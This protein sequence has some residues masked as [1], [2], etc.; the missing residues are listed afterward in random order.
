MFHPKFKRELLKRKTIFELF[1]NAKK[2][3]QINIGIVID[4]IAIFIFLR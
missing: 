3:R 1:M 2:S 4:Y